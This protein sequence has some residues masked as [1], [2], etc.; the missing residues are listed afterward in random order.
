MIK[1][2]ILKQRLTIVRKPKNKWKPVE[3]FEANQ[4]RYTPE[5][6]LYLNAISYYRYINKRNCLTACEYLF[7]AKIVLA[8]LENV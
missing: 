6:E 4:G 2:K 3:L 7:I 5:Q 1:S 8:E